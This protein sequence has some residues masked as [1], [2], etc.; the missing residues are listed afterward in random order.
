MTCE[1]AGGQGGPDAMQSDVLSVTTF[2]AVSSCGGVQV[3]L[4]PRLLLEGFRPARIVRVCPES[5][6][7]QFVIVPPEE[8]VMPG[9]WEN[10]NERV[11]SE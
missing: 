4:K 11:K 8:R 7:W 5:G 2:P 1:P 6:G 9:L 10:R 3:V